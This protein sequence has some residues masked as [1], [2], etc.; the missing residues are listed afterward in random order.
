M[1]AVMAL[2]NGWAG[3]N[4]SHPVAESLKFKGEFCDYQFVA[5]IDAVVLVN[6]DIHGLVN[7]VNDGSTSAFMWEW[8]TTKPWKD[9][10]EVRFVGHRIIINECFTEFAA[11]WLSADTV[12][13]VDDCCPCF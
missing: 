5:P 13:L 12:A 7:S 9:R 10:G 8:F 1:A 11:D 4:D 6:N 2:Q 3:E